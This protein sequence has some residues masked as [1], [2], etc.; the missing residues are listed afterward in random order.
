[1]APRATRLVLRDF[2]NYERAEVA[3]GDGLTVVTG[4]NGAGK[5]NLLEGLYFGLVGRSCRTST[6]REAIR[7][8][9]PAARLEVETVG[10]D[11]RSHRLE[12][13]LAIGEPKRL[14]LDGSVLE[15]PP[16]ASVRPLASV[17]MPDRLAL[18]KGPPTAR[19]AHLDQLSA[20]LWPARALARSAYGHALAQRN[21]ALAGVRAGRS[22]ATALDPWDSELARLGLELMEARAKAAALVAP[23]F[24]ARAD[25]L[26]L[27]EPAELVYAPRSRALDPRQLLE[28]LLERR[29]GDLERG[30]TG[31]GPHRDEL[32]LRHGGR[33]LRPYGSQGQQRVG[34]LALLFA[35]R[36]VL[37]E[38]GGAP[39]MLLDDVTSEL[40]ATRRERLAVLVRAGGQAVVSA[41]ELD[42]VPGGIERGVTHVEV[43]EGTLRDRTPARLATVA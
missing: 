25:E 37:L 42:H 17:F 16:D 31:H 34:L 24:A 7:G 28:E 29:P 12:V 32:L 30:F 3:L 8:G 21:A 11:G 5:T 13:G 43:D 27:P 18:V 36:D 2:R 9:A 1:M 14:A 33:L 22:P 10:A 6:E 20:T 41:T 19:R 35:E 4:P 26:G 38:G 15:R 39:L 40:D 23:G